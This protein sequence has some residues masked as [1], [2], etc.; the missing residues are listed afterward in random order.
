MVVDGW[1]IGKLGTPFRV[2]LLT[3]GWFGTF[4]LQEPSTQMLYVECFDRDYVNAKV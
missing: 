3:H 2:P 4:R 1:A